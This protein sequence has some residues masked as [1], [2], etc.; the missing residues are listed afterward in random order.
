[1]GLQYCYIGPENVGILN[2]VVSYCIFVEV[3]CSFQNYQF[4]DIFTD[5]AYSSIILL[6]YIHR[7]QKLHGVRF[8]E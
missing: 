4:T 5:F 3:Q 1:M 8:E 2:T 7:D 6:V